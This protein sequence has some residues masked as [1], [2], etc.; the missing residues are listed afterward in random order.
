[1]RPQPKTINYNYW[2]EQC[3]KDGPQCSE[4]VPAVY[5]HTGVSEMILDMKM[6]F[7][8]KEFD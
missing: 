2:P 4:T 8:T 7:Y 5:S 3:I 6:V 1:M